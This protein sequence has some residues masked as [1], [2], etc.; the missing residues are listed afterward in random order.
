MK[1][2]YFILIPLFILSLN[3]N[4][5]A[6]DPGFSSSA[7]AK[8]VALNGMYFTGMDGLQ[9]VLGNPS[10][11]ALLNSGGVEM[12]IANHI[13]QHEFKNT[14]N[15]MYKSFNDDDYSFGGGIF[16]SFSPLFT[17][18]LSYQRATDYHV[19]WPYTNLFSLDSISALIA[20][21]FFNEITI[22][23]ATVSTGIGFENFSFG[24]SIHYYFVEHILS[25]PKTNERW[26]Q[27][28]GQAAYQLSYNQDGN[29]FGFN[30][31]VSYQANDQLRFGVFAKSGFKADLDGT[32]SGN[33]LR[34]LDSTASL[35]N[36]N[37]SLEMPWEFGGGI[38]YELN[39]DLKLNFDI[40]YSLWGSIEKSIAIDF[41]NPV[42]Q[43][44]L[45]SIDSLTGIN[46]SNL[47]LSY[48]NSFDAGV[49]LEYY[50]SNLILR[51]G[52]HFSQSPNTDATYN[53]LFP[54]VDQHIISIGIGY[55][56]KNLIIDAAVAYAFGVER[57]VTGAAVKNSSGRYSSSMVLPAVT[58]RYLL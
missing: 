36:I 6:G 31:G 43:Q 54:S 3:I 1:T 48:D 28:L 35:V 23:A 18:A 38:L 11:L 30:L 4:L 26:N 40:K 22:D 19:N 32:A 57:E 52:Y 5:I 50:T 29:A 15:E 33:L 42:W 20:F 9:P 7:R 34:D 44:R 16:W 12:Y 51:T 21:D 41:E 17:A 13:G 46:A 25:F 49:G 47:N 39:E 27:G 45:S 10:V 2:K 14:R 58:L 37:S 53:M 56:D 55:R 24:A 8:T